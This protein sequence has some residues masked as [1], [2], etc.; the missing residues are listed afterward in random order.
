VTFRILTVCTGNICRSPLAE[1]LLRQGLAGVVDVTVASAGTGALV[2]GT[3]PDE[4]QAIAARLGVADAADHRGR[5]VRAADLAEADLV[6]AMARDHRRAIVE[7]SPAATRRTFTVRELAR[8][9]AEITDEEL[10][11]E[12]AGSASADDALRALVALASSFRGVVAPPEAPT[13]LDVVDPYRRSADVYEESAA[14]L[15]PAVEGVVALLTRAAAS[16]AAAR[17]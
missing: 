14:Q 5:Q 11:E 4:A 10:R 9:A 3:M 2:G 15:A 17:P 13:D 1:Q 7:L 12:L 8:I 16:A 6:L